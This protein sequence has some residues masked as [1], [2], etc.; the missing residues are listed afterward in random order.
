MR[1]GRPK[2]PDL[3]RAG[4]LL[5]GERWVKVT[6]LPESLTCHMI[7]AT[8]IADLLDSGVNP[9]DEQDS[10]SH[11]D[12][13]TTRLYDRRMWEVMRNIVERISI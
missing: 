1:G 11:A 6:G 13:R 3:G 2:A 5:G 8:M 4:E 12:L 7:R 10:A 9:D